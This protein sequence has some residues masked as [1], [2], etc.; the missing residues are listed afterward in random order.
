M[1]D[2]AKVPA[3]RLVDQDP[4]GRIDVPIARAAKSGVDAISGRIGV[5]LWGRGLGDV[6]E[7]FIA[8]SDVPSRSFTAVD[9]AR[10]VGILK[11]NPGKGRRR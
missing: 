4:A 10:Q 9:I 3:P 5:D 1:P 11:K 8:E 2:F 7:A 6:V